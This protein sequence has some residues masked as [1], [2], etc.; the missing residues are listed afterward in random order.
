MNESL[1]CLRESLENCKEPYFYHIELNFSEVPSYN[2]SIEALNYLTKHG[3][4]NG[5]L[6]LMHLAYKL[7]VIIELQICDQVNF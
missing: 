3:P 2:V 5:L 6:A 4:Q 7:I 1:R